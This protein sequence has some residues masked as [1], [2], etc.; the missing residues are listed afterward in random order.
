MNLDGKN[1][2]ENIREMLD[3]KH[4]AL[5]VWDVQNALVNAIF[6]KAEFVSELGKLINSARKVNIPVFYTKITPLPFRF[7][8]SP[9][10]YSTMKRMGVSDPRKASFMLPG[11]PE[12]EIYR[13]IAPTQNDIVINKNTADI[14]IGTNF[15]MMVRNAGIESIV[16]TGISTEVGIESSA[17]SAA[18]RGFYV[19]IPEDCVSSRDREMH[20]A[21][22]KVMRTQMIVLRGEEIAKNWV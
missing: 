12:S 11:S 14:F 3:P 7:E 8:S 10:L 21:S 4:T 1:I 5:V 18:N 19:I 22:L 17:R 6:N 2:Y 13:D 9:R 16:F 15:E 20:E